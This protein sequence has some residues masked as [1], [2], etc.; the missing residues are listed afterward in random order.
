MKTGLNLLRTS[1]VKLHQQNYCKC[2]GCINSG[3]IPS[4]S[5]NKG[6]LLEN[7]LQTETHNNSI[8]NVVTAQNYIQT[9][10]WEDQQGYYHTISVRESGNSA[11]SQFGIAFHT[12]SK[13]KGETRSCLYLSVFTHHAKET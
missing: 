10:T 11:N 7:Q 8:E 2:L 6:A 3:L 1:G 13:D 9:T 5:Q 4:C 12:E